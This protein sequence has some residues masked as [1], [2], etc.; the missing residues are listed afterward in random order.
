MNEREALRLLSRTFGGMVQIGRVKTEA[1]KVEAAPDARQ[2]FFADTPAP[3]HHDAHDTEW[4]VAQIKTGTGKRK[5]FDL[6]AA[7]PGGLTD[8]EIENHLGWRRPS[9]SNRRADLATLE[10]VR[11]TGLRRPSPAGRPQIVWALTDK[12][13]KAA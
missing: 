5:V 11:D 8:T 6:L 13:R 4:N 7:F 1:V 3:V 2:D 12:G 10:L 9:G